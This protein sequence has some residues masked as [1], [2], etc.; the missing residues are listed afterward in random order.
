MCCAGSGYGLGV[1]G[2]TN[3]LKSIPGI[4][5]G[6]YRFVVGGEAIGAAALL[7]FYTWHVLGLVLLA[8][9]FIAWHIFRIRRDGGFLRRTRTAHRPERLVRVEVLAMLLTLAVLV[10]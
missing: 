2:G 3:L 4:G 1:H 6:L 7:R 9:G 10:G 5:P 8:S